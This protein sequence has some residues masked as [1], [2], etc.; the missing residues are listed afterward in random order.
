[1]S[2]LLKTVK[3]NLERNTCNVHNQKPTI[4]ISGDNLSLDCC[5]EDFKTNLSKKI[6][7]EVEKATAEMIKKMFN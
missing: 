1:M 5:C 4:K 7:T 2:D 3:Q 6:K